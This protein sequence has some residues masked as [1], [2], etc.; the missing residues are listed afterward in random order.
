MSAINKL[1]FNQC[2]NK[3]GFRI[4]VPDQ[5]MDAQCLSSFGSDIEETL[6]DVIVECRDDFRLLGVAM[7][8]MK[9]HSRLVIVEKFFKKLSAQNKILA[10]DPLLNFLIATAM[11]NGDMKWKTGYKYSKKRP[12]FPTDRQ[13][14]QALIDVKGLDKNFSKW[15][16]RIPNGYLSSKESNV[17]SSQELAQSNKQYRNRLIYGANWRADIITA[18]EEGA[19]TATEITKLIGC[20]YEPAHR[21]FRDFRMATSSI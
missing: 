8:W 14:L 6:L 19:A 2:L 18:I 3:I 9:L 21:V 5:K 15:G 12:L 16:V 11:V 17:L 13:S 1:P 20:S 7:T 10:D 4:G